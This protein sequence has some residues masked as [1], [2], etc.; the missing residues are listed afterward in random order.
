[1]VGPR[2]ILSILCVLLLSVAGCSRHNNDNKL[3]LRIGFFPNIT[4]V[5][6]LLGK[7]KIF[8]SAAGCPIEWKKFN[9]G[10]TEIEAL[11]AGE[12]DMGYIGPGPAING[13]IKTKGEIQIIAGAC[14]GG[15]VLVSR[16]DVV[17]RSV[18]ELR[19]KRIAIPQF[20][21]TQH[22]VLQQLLDS[23]GLKETSKGGSVEIVQAENPD[24]KTLFDQ[25]AIDAAFVPEPWASRL[26]EEVRANVVLEYD[27]VW[28]NGK[29]PTAVLIVR[30][31]FMKVHPDIVA[32]FVAAHSELTVWAKSN[33][34]EAKKIVNTEIKSLTGKALS[35]AVLSAAYGR[36]II[37]D[38]VDAQAV[39][40]MAGVM[41]RLG[42]IK[43]AY[44]I[45]KIFNAKTLTQ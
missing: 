14:E 38:R 29:Y 34:D 9:A 27:K 3:T 30:T 31:D 42:V 39:A 45:R 16:R 40:E 33:K 6:A 13:F 15:A 11:I 2:T 41:E 10:S 28:R 26:I 7:G 1:M 12:L 8:E 22:V 36:L 20:G 37:T 18:E 32:K 17:I 25:Q 21:N 19:N 43:G 23:K 5:Q 44:D 24:V 4:H 35:D